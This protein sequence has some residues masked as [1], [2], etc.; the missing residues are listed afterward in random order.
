MRVPRLVFLLLVAAIAV[1]SPAAAQ[2]DTFLK[3][4]VQFHQTLRGA[5]GDEG[6]QL[7]A[8]LDTMA[9]AL[10]A[11]DS[12]IRNAESQLRARAKG[13]DTAAA[14]QAHTILASLYLERSRFDDA[15]REFEADIQIDP[16]RAAFHRYKG[17]IYQGM[18]RPAEAAAAYRTAWLRDPNDPQNAYQLVVRRA[19]TTTAAQLAQALATLVRVEGELVRRQR[20]RADSPFRTIQAIDDDAGASI[21]FVPPAY[22][23]GFSLLQR[24]AYGEALTVLRAAVA[25]DPL[26]TDGASRSEPMAQGIAALRQGMVDAALE[27]LEAAVARAADSSEAHRILGTAYGING[28]AAK[29]VQHLRDATRLNPRDERGWLGL[30]RALED[31]GELPEAVAALRSGMSA[32]PDSASLR[33]RLYLTSAKRQR[34]DESDLA[35]LP[36]VDR[37][38]LFAGKGELY[39]QLARLAQAHLD[40]ERGVALLEQRVTLTP[41]NALAHKALGLAYVEQGREDAG[42]AE[43]VT[44]LLLD[45]LDTETLTA[46]GQA[47][48]AAGRTTEAIAGLERALALDSSNN[49]ALHALGEALIR[50]GRTAEGQQ[51]LEESARRREQDVEDQRSRRTAAVLTLQAEEHMAKGEYDAAID[52]WRQAIAIRRDSVGP[53][54]MS[55]ALIKAGR[56]EEAAILLRAS[57]SSTARPEMHSRLAEVYAALGRTEESAAA[58]RASVEKRLQELATAADP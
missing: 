40:Y 52:V 55:D 16:A 26:V 39:G 27:R 48:L 37:L 36:L 42:Y 34:T 3:A 33:W 15:L 32:L 53:L 57:I 38:V 56:L 8:H 1:P 44:S 49:Q 43:L 7:T 41:N 28:D 6:P 30:A 13:T 18:A 5:Y 21:A 25:A 10:A 20:S 24:G 35:L 45:P 4:L 14:L 23:R 17:L 29:S 47:H 22:I 12:E 51:R 31:S 58:R 11:W 9:A 2:R 50:A 54:R 46:L 19:S